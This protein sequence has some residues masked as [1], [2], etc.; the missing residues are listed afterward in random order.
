MMQSGHWPPRAVVEW[1]RPQTGQRICGLIVVTNRGGRVPWVSAR[2]LVGP[3]GRSM[4]CT[5]YLRNYSEKISEN[6]RVRRGKR[7]NFYIFPAG[8]IDC[9]G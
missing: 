5:C 6:T 4:S 2:V 3:V 9:L 7:L 1:V 8:V